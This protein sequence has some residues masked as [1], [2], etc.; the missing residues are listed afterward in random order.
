M[1]T[2]QN[3]VDWHGSYSIG[4]PLIDEQHK[5]LVN[6]TNKLYKSCMAG[7]EASKR[8][9]MRTIRSAVDY[10]GYHFSTEEKIMARINYPGFAAHKKEH[11][12][13]VK[14]VL[15]EVDEFNRGNKFT[16]TN[17]VRYLKDWVLTHIAVSDKALGDYLLVI[18]KGGGLAHI[19]LKVKELNPDG[20]N[21]GDG[22]QKNSAKRYAIA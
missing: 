17:F 10:I 19:T 11:A 4:I 3:L 20:E 6:L 22:D 18:K 8:N 16:P 1:A 21:S 12:S 15:H 9:F 2:E 13:F 14:E 5:E 7:G